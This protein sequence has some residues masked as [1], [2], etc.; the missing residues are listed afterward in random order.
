LDRALPDSSKR[1]QHIA[2]IRQEL[3][4]TERS[5]PRIVSGADPLNGSTPAPDRSSFYSKP[6]T[7]LTRPSAIQST[8]PL[9]QKHPGTAQSVLPLIDRSG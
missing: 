9:P 8:S 2:A 7:A 4:K 1:R 3:L 5:D 6:L